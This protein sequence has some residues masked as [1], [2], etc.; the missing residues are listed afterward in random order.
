MWVRANWVLLPSPTSIHPTLH[1]ANIRRTYSSPL[2]IS[3]VGIETE[4]KGKLLCVKGIEWCFLKE[5]YP[6]PP[7]YLILSSNF[8]ALFSPLLSKKERGGSPDA[9]T[10]ST[11][12]ST[13]KYWPEQCSL[14]FIIAKMFFKRA[15]KMWLNSRFLVLL[16]PLVFGQFSHFN[17]LHTNME[18]LKSWSPFNFQYIGRPLSKRNW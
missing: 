8:L 10:F 16:S 6:A 7:D 9:L 4:I 3:P 12:P 13:E 2:N 5:K 11:D 18:C 14:S 15:C 1:S 17:R